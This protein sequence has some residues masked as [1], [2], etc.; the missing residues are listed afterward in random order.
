MEL[1]NL[2]SNFN[3]NHTKKEEDINFSS[4]LDYIYN[5]M[6]A[7]DHGPKNWAFKTDRKAHYIRRARAL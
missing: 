3:Q 7:F 1:P 4:K 6:E 2:A 5:R